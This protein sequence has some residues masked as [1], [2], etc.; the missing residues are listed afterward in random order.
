MIGKHKIMKNTIINI[1][2]ELNNTINSLSFMDQY[3]LSKNAF[4]RNRLLNFPTL[5]IYLLNLRKHSNQVELDQFFKIINNEKEASQV[6]T[7]QAFFRARKKL[8]YTAFIALNQQIISSTYQS[9]QH[10]KTWHG[11]RL[12][13]VD[14]TSIRL[15]NTP[16]IKAHFGVQKGKEG[17]ADCTL[18][19][20]SIFYDVLNHLVIDSSLHS[21]GYSER[22]CIPEHLK[23]SM[24]NDLILYD[25]GYP[26]FWVYALHIHHKSTF[27]IRTKTKQLLIVKE[28]I[29]SNKRE[30]IV[31]IKPNATSLQTCL[32][33]G[34][35][36][37]VI[38][39]RLVRVDLPDE[40]EVL[41]TNLM[42]TE[43]YPANLFKA[44]Y[45]LRWGIEENYKC[46]KQWV[47]IENFSGK[48]VLSVQQD[49]YAKIVAS[50]LT[51][52]MK[53]SAQKKV[54][55]RTQYF[56]LKY[57]VNS[58]QALS[59]MKHQLVTFIVDAHKGISLKI[60]RIIDY[61]SIT[62]EAV[63]EGRSVPRN[64]KNIKNDIH[65]SAYKS[66]L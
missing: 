16:D 63:R 22:E 30:Q 34:L 65:F 15:P 42:D 12:C 3:R 59:K 28:F 13:A 32:D 57:Q 1:Y 33:K 55:K 56:R 51:T 18:G 19:M 35:P 40:V 36:T 4:I 60:E 47:E 43:K 29:K 53:I 64:L 6:I 48:S 62:I 10:L 45:H 61:I 25:R 11:F 46:L 66:S 52:L 7:K 2:K 14:G 58:A 44:L 37:E 38:K 49:F 17:Q 24:K 41:I 39:L 50:N 27:C 26:A 20:A 54:D 23:H 8:S 21:N 31:E 9:N 5:I